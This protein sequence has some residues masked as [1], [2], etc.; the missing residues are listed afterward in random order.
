[1]GGTA[2]YKQHEMAQIDSQ[3]TGADNAAPADQKLMGQTYRDSSWLLSS[4]GIR[5]VIQPL[6]PAVAEAVWQRVSLNW[7]F[8]K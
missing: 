5:E 7:W 4:I 1:M 6:G 8:E 3:N 2:K